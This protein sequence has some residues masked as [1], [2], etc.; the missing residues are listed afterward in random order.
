MSIKTSRADLI[1]SW[2]NVSTGNIRDNNS[3][4]VTPALMRQA[5]TDL[6]DTLADSHQTVADI[7]TLNS[8]SLGTDFKELDIIFV[9][10]I[11]K[12][13]KIGVYQYVRNRSTAL[14]SWTK[15]AELG[16]STKLIAS[17]QA[18]L[19]NYISTDFT[20]GDLAIGYLV[21]LTTGIIYILVQNDGSS[22]GD[23]QKL[24][25]QL[26]DE[27]A[28]QLGGQLDVNGKALGD[29]TLELLKFEETASAVNEL[30]IKNNST[31]N[32]PQLKATG[33]DANI[34]I[35]LVPKGTGK[36]KTYS[37][38]KQTQGSDVA[39]AN[40]LS[41][42]GATNGNTWSITGTTQINLI[43]SSQ[44][45]NG[46]EISLKF[47]GVLT[48]KDNQTTSGNYKKINL[49]GGEDYET[50]AGDVICLRLV[51][52]E[53]FEIMSTKGG[54]SGAGG[55]TIADDGV[56][57]TARGTLNFIG[58]TM[59]DDAGNDET[60]VEHLFGDESNVDNTNQAEG[61]A[62]VWDATNGYYTDQEQEE[63]DL[64]LNLTETNLSADGQLSLYLP[65]GYLIEHIFV[66]ETAAAAAGN[67]SI[68]TAA[69]GTQ[70]VNA[71]TVGASADAEMTLVAGYF[72]ITADTD[73]YVS[74]SSWG[75]GVIS[76]MIVCRKI[77]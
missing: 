45:Q 41:L 38:I 14:Y 17:T 30:T 10:D 65:A 46:T 8:L 18:T 39:S 40:N 57:M 6:Y 34:D 54:S 48:I 26:V 2:E 61:T 16:E 43:D 76:L 21:I 42:T 33:D 12:G 69:S 64:L 72:S 36:I 28:P 35:G 19:A 59:T 20:T 55:H 13:D 31:G 3:K 22:T 74:S 4:I 24:T 63:F 1:T 25:K 29:G 67:I 73:L 62:K 66:N 37:A 60:E 32:D 56:G 77:W 52:D 70:V 5:V 71:F 9:S 68:G 75:S 50:V 47:D 44:W 7:T 53:W 51:D 58:F 15:I 23:Y 11:G 49:A 27:T